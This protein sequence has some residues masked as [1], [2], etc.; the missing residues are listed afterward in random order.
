MIAFGRINLGSIWI[1]MAVI[2]F[3]V[4]YFTMQSLQRASA[5]QSQ[6]SF[7]L[8]AVADKSS[9]YHRYQPRVK[10]SVMKQLM[11]GRISQSVGNNLVGGNSNGGAEVGSSSGVSGMVNGGTSR[12][13]TAQSAFAGAISLPPPSFEQRMRDM[14]LGKPKVDPHFSA[15]SRSSVKRTLPP[16]LQVIETLQ[17]YK[18][19]V[20]DERQKIVVVRFYATYCKACQSVA[21]HFYRLAKQYPNIIFVDVPVTDRNTALHQGLGIPTLPFAHIYH[22]ICGLVEEQKFTRRHVSSFEEKLSCYVDGSCPIPAE[23]ATAR[24]DDDLL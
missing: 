10:T 19:V 20:G 1:D 24:D 22:P 2:C 9:I 14:V 17:K 23:S 21:P 3:S 15:F 13:S 12:P 4:I 7:S 16:N 18:T 5:L 8:L 11:Q 6:P